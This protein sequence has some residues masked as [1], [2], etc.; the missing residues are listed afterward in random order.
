M[1]D[2]LFHHLD[3][4]N[5]KEETTVVNINSVTSDSFYGF[6]NSGTCRIEQEVKDR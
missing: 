6:N 2:K 4:S 1:I 3:V 5:K